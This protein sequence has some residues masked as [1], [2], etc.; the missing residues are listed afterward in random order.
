MKVGLLWLRRDLRLTDNPA[1]HEAL[2]AC[3]RVVPVYIHAPE[4]EGDW[5][6]GAASRWWLHHSLA[7]L[8]T[9]LRRRGSRLLL[10]R[11]PTARTLTDLAREVG[12][13]QVFCNRLYEPTIIQRDAD[14]ERALH[15]S[16]IAVHSHNAGLLH[17]PWAIRKHDHGPYR[18]FTPY[19]NAGQK[20]GLDRPLQPRPKALPPVPSRLHGL[21]LAALGLLP[22]R[23]WDEGLRTA[24]Q[25]G[26]HGARQWLQIFLDEALARYGERRDQPDAAGTSRLSPHLHFGELGPRQIWHALQREAEPHAQRRAAA[27]AYMR[28]LGW[29]EFSQQLLYHY[30][31]SADQP[32]DP[33]FAHMPW[34]RKPA[35]ALQA[36]RKG[37]TGIPIVDAGMRELWH[38]GWMHN[39]VRML[40]ASLLTK[41][42]LVPWQQGARWFWETLVDADLGNNTMGWQWTAGC[43]ADAAPYFRIFNPVLQGERFDPDGA[44]V[45]TW[46]PELARLPNRYV[47]QPWNAPEKTLRQAGVRP[48]HDYPAPIIDLKASRERALAAYEAIRHRPAQ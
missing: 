25:P 5:A 39:R 7:A 26:E 10:R 45:R 42:L 19:W 3:E 32:L 17:E 18:V 22:V 15:A 29:R 43:G 13:G 33:R 6:P 44:Y 27:D 48:D 8:D 24:W 34:A 28:Q 1:L 36:W 31:H 41:N 16:D 21:G 20:A 38:S 2:Q 47:H 11:G 4:E 37:E 14:V 23:P 35:A 46:V 12:A 40:S 9:A 30:P